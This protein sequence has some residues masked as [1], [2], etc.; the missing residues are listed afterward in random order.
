MRR[1]GVVTVSRSDYGIYRPVLKRLA[2]DVGI[3]LGLYVGGSHFAV[4]FGSTIR[5]IEADGFPIQARI[6]A[7]PHDDAP[8]SIA[9]AA[10]RATE[11][12]SRA[13]AQGR[14]GLVVVLGDRLD[15]HAAAVAALPMRIPIAH[16]HGG[17]LTY[18]A[19]DESIR[20]SMTKLSHLHFVS[21]AEYGR[22]VRQLGEEAWRVVVSGA[23]GLDDID[24]TSAPDAAALDALGVPAAAAPLLVTF[25]PATLEF[26]ETGAQADE[27][28]AALDTLPGPI[29]FTMPAADAGG[30]VIAS[31]IEAFV[32][33]HSD[34]RFVRS[35]GTAGYFSLM[36]VARAMVGNSSSGII[37]A[38]SFRL[39]VVN[40]GS[41]QDGRIR[42]ANVIDCPV[43]RNAITRAISAAVDPRFKAGL[44]GR[45]PYGDGRASETI[46]R[47]LADVELGERLIVKRFC[48]W[49]EA[50]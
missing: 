49:P 20:H 47:H 16:L 11:G 22:R 46:A 36:R 3:S 5:E 43:E 32:S 34:A 44:D 40:I 14:P 4:E 33:T 38:A 35:L 28:L 2:A 1:I 12:F 8:A 21:T 48:D 24:T 9:E 18:G 15:M 26:A 41:R 39:P 42:A 6:D 45:N 37:E 50:R 29:I 7:V 10:G 19:I 30:R 17:E 31:R 23:P 25:H 13:F 27:L